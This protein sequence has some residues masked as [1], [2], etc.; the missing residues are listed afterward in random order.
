MAEAAGV[1]VR[2]YLPNVREEGLAV[3]GVARHGG[4]RQRPAAVELLVRVRVRVR[5]RVCLTL[6]LTP[7]PN[8]NPNRNPNPNLALLDVALGQPRVQPHV[9]G[10]GPAR[11][12]GVRVQRRLDL[13][14][15]R[16][17]ARG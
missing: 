17:K 16:V 7:N 12:D 5:V 4:V 2:A 10:L 8:P 3:V 9:R 1:S 15:V 14:R 6:T 11:A 13:V